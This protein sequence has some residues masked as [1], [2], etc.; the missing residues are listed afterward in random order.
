M[1]D[2]HEDNVIPSPLHATLGKLIVASDALK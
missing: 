1:T 2:L